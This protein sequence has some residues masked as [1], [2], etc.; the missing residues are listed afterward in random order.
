MATT[1][2][3][4]AAGEYYSSTTGAKS[5]NDSQLPNV[6]TNGA[7]VITTVPTKREVVEAATKQIA[8]SDHS[9]WGSQ[10]KMH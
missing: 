1:Y 10:V 2:W 9:I 4:T 8:I 6:S 7:T 5:A 3:V